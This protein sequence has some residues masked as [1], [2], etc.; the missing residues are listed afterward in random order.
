MTTVRD[1]LI[2]EALENNRIYKEQLKKKKISDKVKVKIEKSKLK[3]S[4]KQVNTVTKNKIKNVDTSQGKMIPRNKLSSKIELFIQKQNDD[5]LNKIWEHYKVKFKQRKY[6]S[7]SQFARLVFADYVL[8]KKS[9]DKWICTCVTCW[10]KLHRSDPQMHPWHFRTAGTSLKY[11]F[12]L[13]NVRPQNYYCN[14]A[15][16]WNYWKYTLFMIDTFGRDRVDNILS[17]KSLF[18]IKDFE[19]INMIKEWWLE[20][21]LL[22]KTKLTD[23]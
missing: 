23:I 14:V 8:L 18:K 13:D 22:M 17:D 3:Q 16:H 9:D 6:K 10:D 21:E 5:I 20:V 11:K 2:Y 12:V 4:K 15:L 1:V 7:M 19:Y